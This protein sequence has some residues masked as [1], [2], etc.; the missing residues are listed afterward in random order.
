MK[1]KPIKSTKSKAITTPETV[2]NIEQDIFDLKIQV[3]ELQNKILE[4]QRKLLELKGNVGSTKNFFNGCS[5][6][7]FPDE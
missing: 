7:D 4:K 2:I 3:N 5:T 6:K 1:S